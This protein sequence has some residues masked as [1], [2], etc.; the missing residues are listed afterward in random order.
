[1]KTIGIS[2]SVHRELISLKLQEGDKNA[3]ELISKLILEYKKNKFLEASALFRNKLHGKK[4]DLRNL[5]V[6]SKKIREEI[7]DEWLSE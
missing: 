1:M 5:L 4:M 2:E 7:A 3:G 6:K